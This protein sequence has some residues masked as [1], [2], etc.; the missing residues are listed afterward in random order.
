MVAV[1]DIKNSICALFEVYADAEGTHR[2]VTPLEYSGSNDRIVVRVR[3]TA[4]GGY[5]IDENGEAAHFALLNGGDVDSDSVTRWA[6]EQES[7]CPA[8]FDSKT[9]VISAYANDDR[10]ISPYIF[11][12]AQAAH[13]LYTL[14]TAR[15]ERQ[16][17][18]FR[19]RVKAVIREMAAEL[20]VEFKQDVELPIMGA[21]KADAVLSTP[22]PIVVIA[23]TSP[24]RL[25]QAELIHM[26]YRAENKKARV[27]AVAESQNAVGKKEF[28]RALYFTHKTVVFNGEAFGDLV[29]A[30]VTDMPH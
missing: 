26:Q 17:S 23:A 2:I 3:P 28:E 22:V 11:R 20:H 8:L 19:D 16:A 9:E 5:Q 4:D 14:A 6:E 25:L 24:V 1:K 27:L 29:K 7:H 18:D 13:Q 15:Q 30:E 10:L 21:M 12:V